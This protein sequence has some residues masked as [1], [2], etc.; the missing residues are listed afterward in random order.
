[1]SEG[2]VCLLIMYGWV[3]GVFAGWM[4]FSPHAPKNRSQLW[5]FIRFKRYDIH[6]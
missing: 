3:N 4:Y 2:M 5:N 6:T 1:M